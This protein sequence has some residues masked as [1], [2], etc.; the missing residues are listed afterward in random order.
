MK[1]NIIII[2]IAL[3]VLLFIAFLNY[4]NSPNEQNNFDKDPGFDMVHELEV[5]PSSNLDETTVNSQA[6]T[7]DKTI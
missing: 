7:S 6:T 4:T 2:I 5:E 3:A 1:K